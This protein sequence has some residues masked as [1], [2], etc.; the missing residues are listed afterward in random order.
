M[1]LRKLKVQVSCVENYVGI[2][3]VTYRACISRWTPMH[4][5]FPLAFFNQGFL[6]HQAQPLVLIQGC[7][8]ASAETLIWLVAFSGTTDMRCWAYKC[9]IYF[10][11]LKWGTHLLMA[12]WRLRDSE[13]AFHAYKRRMQGKN[14]VLMV[15]A[16][17]LGTTPLCSPP[18]RSA[19]SAGN[20]WD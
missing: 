15:T 1:Q 11:I 18:S 12:Y 9:V 17:K 13:K 5:P 4:P 2:F 19:G 3:Q 14:N 20:R 6:E 8:L 16:R 7:L 10:R